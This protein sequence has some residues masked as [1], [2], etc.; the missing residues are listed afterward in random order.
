MEELKSEMFFNYSTWV[1]D[2]CPWLEGARVEKHGTHQDIRLSNLLW[3]LLQ[4]PLCRV[5]HSI[6]FI[7]IF[8]Q[9]ADVVVFEAKLALLPL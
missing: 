4:T 8:V 6:A 1:S 2:C 3:R 9:V 5:Y 7:D